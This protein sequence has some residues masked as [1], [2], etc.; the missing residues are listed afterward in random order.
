MNVNGSSSSGNFA[1]HGKG[2]F[3][4]YKFSYDLVNRQVIIPYNQQMIVMGGIDIE[5]ELIID[6]T[7]ILET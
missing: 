6:G 1:V 7:L 4:D 5:C 3:G 2:L